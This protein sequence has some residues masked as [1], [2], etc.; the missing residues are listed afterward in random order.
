MEDNK[1]KQIAKDVYMLSE[2]NVYKIL[3][4]FGKNQNVDITL[5][6][7]FVKAF[8]IRVVAVYMRNHGRAEDFDG[9]YSEY[10]RELLEYY[11]KNNENIPDDLL[12]D[13]AEAFDKSF[14]I[15]ESLD[16]K[17]IEDSYE[18]RHHIVDTFELL[19]KILEK[20]SKEDIRVDIFENHVS[21]IKAE[22]EDI[23]VYIEKELKNAP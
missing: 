19:R 22:A 3:D 21:K 5:T 15:I 4:S 8:Y 9:I 12:K 2:E 13:I 23:I 11:K 14:D 20:K 16:F 7:C 17:M 10:K 18:F 6:Y 1:K